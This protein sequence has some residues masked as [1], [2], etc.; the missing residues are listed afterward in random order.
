MKTC[1]NEVKGIGVIAA[2]VAA[3]VMSCLSGCLQLT[4]ART[5]D[6]WGAKF[7]ANSGFE[8]SAGVQ[9]YNQILDKKGMDSEKLAKNSLE[10]R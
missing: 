9:Q 1:E 3:L 5:I 2:I 4:G 8:V 7:E 10:K 6:L